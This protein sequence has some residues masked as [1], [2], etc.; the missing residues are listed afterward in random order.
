MKTIKQGEIWYT[1]LNPIKGREQAG[2]RPVV[3]V[4]GNVVNSYL[5]IV[6]A[7]PLTTIIKNYKGDIVLHPNSINGLSQPSEVL[8]FHIRSLSK[9]RLEK[10]IGTI[11]S[12][13]LA[14]LKEGLDDILRY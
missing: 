6:I 13:E 1:N 3:I 2:H 12:D 9:D 7:M 5:D 10:K 11:T 4:S 14:E 8:I